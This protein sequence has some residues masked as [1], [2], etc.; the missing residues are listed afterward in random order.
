MKRLRTSLLAVAALALLVTMALVRDAEAEVRFSA[1]LRTPTVSVR[2][3]NAHRGPYGHVRI[4]R[5]PVR[6]RRHYRIVKH[7][8]RVAR[9]L[10][11]YTGVH[12]R[13]LIRLRAYGYTWFE[14]GRWLRL[15][16]RVVRA[17]FNKHSWKRFT[18]GGGRLARRPGYGEI[19]V[20]DQ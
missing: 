12:F 16:R 6:P 4:G 1:A 2:I 11:R 18:R 10:A 15:P 13:E 9:R 14:I 3:G 8:R 5:L 7:D 17:A 19:I 20:Y